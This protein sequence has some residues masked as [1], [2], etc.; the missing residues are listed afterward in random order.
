MADKKRVDGPRFTTPRG[1]FRFPKL[2]EID[3]GTDE[4]PK[5]NGEYSVQLVLALN[6]PATQKMIADLKPLHEQ[7]VAIAQQ[8]FAQLKAETRKKLKEV[9]V[10]DLYT[11]ELDQET[12]EPTGNI[13]FK[14]S[15]KASGEYS[16][17][18]KA[19]KFWDCRPPV[20]AADKELLIAGFNFRDRED[21]ETLQEVHAKGKPNIWGGTV[22]KV[23]FE[24]GVDRET[25]EPGYFVPG[26]GAA[27]LKLALRGVQVIDLVSGGQRTADDYGFDNEA[28][29][30]A[31]AEKDDGADF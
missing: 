12:E 24:V 14:F 27:G 21:D 22:G 31:E 13:I 15:M 11:E 23:S 3:F 7:A 10:N 25:G 6:D 16:K 17:G 19:G 28:G 29:E 1:T 5:P 30:D 8:K 26:T 18:K 20:F 2:S 9:K 4:Y